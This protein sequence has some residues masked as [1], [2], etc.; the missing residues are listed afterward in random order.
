MIE[1]DKSDGSKKDGSDI[2]SADCKS[3]HIVPVEVLDMSPDT[4]TFQRELSLQH[5]WEWN[6]MIG[7]N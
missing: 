3:S 7:P 2:E 6:S 1:I 5:S 4:P